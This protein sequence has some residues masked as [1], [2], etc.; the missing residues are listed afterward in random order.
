MG[1]RPCPWFVP[2]NWRMTPSPPLA[3]DG[4][5]LRR[6]VAGHQ[7]QQRG[8]ARAVRPDQRGR[9]PL[10]DAEA[11]VVEERP[12]VRQHVADVRYLDMP[13]RAHARTIAARRRAGNVIY[14]RPE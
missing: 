1:V 2:M 11:H 5:L 7:P 9:D 3:R 10:A 6:Q 12:P 4:A 13:P 8:L 14:R